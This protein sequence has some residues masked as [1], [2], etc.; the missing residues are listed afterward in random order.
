VNAVGKSKDINVRRRMPS[1]MMTTDKREVTLLWTSK[2][3]WRWV[4]ERAV[5]AVVPPNAGTSHQLLAEHRPTG[6]LVTRREMV[7]GQSHAAAN[8][9]QKSDETSG[10]QASAKAGFVPALFRMERVSTVRNLI[11]KPWTISNP[12]ESICSFLPSFL[13]SLSN[14]HMLL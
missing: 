12:T 2:F 13:H 4:F 1:M 11:D 8:V 6:R 14:F 7:I 9:S 3:E 5:G 10:S